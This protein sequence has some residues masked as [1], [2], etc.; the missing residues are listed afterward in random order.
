MVDVLLFVHVPVPL[1]PLI[2]V[3]KSKLAGAT[4]SQ[5]STGGFAVPDS[6]A[7]TIV[8]EMVSS[9]VHVPLSTV[10]VNS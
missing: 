7:G 3:Y 4:P 2:K 9:S 6:G 5:N 1:S 8:I 10:Y